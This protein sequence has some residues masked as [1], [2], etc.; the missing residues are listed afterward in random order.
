MSF[1]LL[2]A[3]LLSG[4][5]GG[6]SETAATPANVNNTS[7]TVTQPVVTPPPVVTPTPVTPPVSPNKVPSALDATATLVDGTAGGITLV[8]VDLDG[9]VV[10]YVVVSQ[11]AHGTLGSIGSDGK[12]K[13]TPTAGYVG[14]DSFTY[15][16][17]DGKADSAVATV[18]L[19]VKA[20]A[21]G[22]TTGSTN[23]APV[24]VAGSLTLSNSGS[25]WVKLE[26]TDADGDTLT[27]RIVT[28]PA[29]GTLKFGQGNV[30]I[31]TPPSSYEGED[32]FTFVAN[33]G[34]VDSAAATVGGEGL[35]G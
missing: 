20:K 13:Y 26:A 18:K 4:C 15:K 34:K 27:F 1:L 11:P 21:D 31:Y 23:H 5:G 10:R 28:Q 3:L 29:H 25:D 24:A 8:A 17:N 6:G 12:V 16:V 9:D 7:D 33:D 22:G 19:T 35:Y 2:L 32:S 14:A 30:Y